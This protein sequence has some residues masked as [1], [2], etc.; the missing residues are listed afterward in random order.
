MRIQV[1]HDAPPTTATQ[2]P[3]FSVVRVDTGALAYQE[4]LIGGEYLVACTSAMA[5]PKPRET[6]WRELGSSEQPHPGSPVARQSRQRAFRLVVDGQ[7]LGDRW[8]WLGHDESPDDERGR[9]MLSV[10]L[11]HKLRPI[12]VT[13]H[14]RIDGT[15]FIERWLT[16]TNSGDAPAAI[17]DVSPWSGQLWDAIGHPWTAIEPRTLPNGPFVLGR[18]TES[19]AGAEGSFDW[20]PLPAGSEYAYACHHGRSGWGLPWFVVRNEATG[21]ACIGEMAW[22]GNWRIA[23]AN[24]YEA[25]PWPPS[26]GWDVRLFA[27]I[28]MA[29][30]AP[31]RVLAPGESCD[32]PSVHIGWVQGDLQVCAEHW[33]THIRRSVKLPQPED[34]AHRVEINHTGWT[35]N[36][37]VTEH[38]LYEEID[39][40]A[41]AGFELFMLD[42]GWFG[43]V[44]DNWGNAVGDWD[45]ENPLLTHGVRAA[46]DRVHDRGMLAGLWV[47]AERLGLASETRAAHPEWQMHR[48]DQEIPNLDLSKPEVEAYLLHVVCDLVDRYELDCFRLDY[49]INIGEGGDAVR[50]GLSENVLWR[51]YDALYR[52][53]DAVRS[54]YPDLLLENCSSGGGRM[55]LGI[56]ARFHWTQVTDKWSPPMTLRVI[57][58]MTL[59]LPPEMHE[60]ILGAISDGQADTDF[61]T[62]IALFGHFCASGVMPSLGEIQQ[63][64]WRRWRHAIQLYKERVRPMLDT[65]RLI[66]H[67]PIQRQTAPGTW[68]VLECAAADG[69][70]AHVG[71]FRLEAAP[72]DAYLL[73]P[74]GLDLGRTY[75]VTYDTPRSNGHRQ[76]FDMTG[77]QLANQGLLVRVPGALRSELVLLDAID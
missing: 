72:S 29:G 39:L 34:R 59:A 24:T 48:G 37:Q 64:G 76:I 66:H 5:R 41:E 30:P 55:D 63:Y 74:R 47:E 38:Q 12:R 22:S 11:Q 23:F 20:V 42:A 40:A 14:T 73:R 70:S 26:E 33:H 50:S 51:H 32:T 61:V 19:S 69:A 35:R 31:L 68:C 17:S 2:V 1:T 13:V 6:V 3:P 44:S 75:R 18:Y 27:E 9:R 36:A 62:R 60:T 25:M 16:V 46:L 15:P 7:L 4:A 45:H 8:S 43:D 28:S 49:N 56:M 77:A 54:R 71:V 10:H 65:C 52:V 53:F 58:G 21:S 67:T 57:N